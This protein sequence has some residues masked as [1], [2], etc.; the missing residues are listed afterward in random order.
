MK[1]SVF[2]SV[3]SGLKESQVLNYINR[4]KVSSRV[5]LDIKSASE[6]SDKD[7]AQFLNINEKTFKTYRSSDKIL[8]KDLQEHSLMFI[9]LLKHGREVFGN[10]KEFVAWLKRHNFHFNGPPLEYLDT[11]SGIKFVD[12]FLTGIQ[13]GDNV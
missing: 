5:F 8:K 1:S 10:Y 6:L 12:D 13:Y 3:P 11:I 9:S 4:N 7:I 2:E